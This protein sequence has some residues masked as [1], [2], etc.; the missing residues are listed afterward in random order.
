[1]TTDIRQLADQIARG[2]G[3]SLAFL[4]EKGPR[5][6]LLKA[7]G[8]TENRCAVFAALA[9]ERI[10]GGPRWSSTDIAAVFGTSH[11]TVLTARKR[12]EEQ[13]RREWIGEFGDA[14]VGYQP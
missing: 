12:I 2:L 4:S 8:R 3:T 13:Q 7:D 10:A 5:G 1:M 14:A 6:G 9:A 11:S